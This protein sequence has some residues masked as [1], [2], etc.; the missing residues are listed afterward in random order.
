MK[1]GNKRKNGLRSVQMLLTA[2]ILMTLNGC[3]TKEA[4]PVMQQ[5]ENKLVSGNEIVLEPET[6]SENSSI[7]GNETVYEE[8]SEAEEQAVAGEGTVSGNQIDGDRKIKGIYVSGPIAGHPKMDELIELVDETELNALVIDV[9]NDDGRITYHMDSGQVKELGASMNLVSDMDGLIRKCKEKDIYLIARIVAFKDPYLAEQRPELCIRRKTGEMFR[10][11]N[12]LAWVNP[13][14]KEVWDYLVEVAS[15]AAADGFDEIQFDYIRFST[16]LKPDQL[17]FGPEAEE[18]GRTDVITEFT[19][20]AY[21]KLSPLGVKVAADVYGTVIDNQVDQDLVG[22]QYGTMAEHLDYICP[23]VYP[24]H[25]GPGNFGLSV[26]DAE[27]YETI[28]AAMTRSREVL[29]Q[30]PGERRAG[31]RVWLQAFTAKW[32][33]GHISYGPEQIRSQIHGAYDAGYEEWILW[34]A[35]VNY[36]REALLTDEEAAEETGKWAEE[37]AERAAVQENVSGNDEGGF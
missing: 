10:D 32:V 19:G 18:K 4:R 24:S 23:M 27:P 33:K 9:K 15:Q 8:M 20:Y 28:F 11:K 22:Q 37:K 6:V 25:Y 29:E 21:E 3:G 14:R 36:K 26:P 2:V 1:K 31:V 16:D 7:S 35:A 13:Y 5:K 30:I 17:D 12:G 34:N